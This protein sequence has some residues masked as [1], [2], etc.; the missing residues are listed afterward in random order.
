[1]K[2]NKQNT[3]TQHSNIEDIIALLTGTFLCSFALMLMQQAGI[4]TGGTAGLALLLHYATKLNFS[5][6]FFLV[7]IPFYYLAYKRLGT[8]MLLKTFV[9]IALLSIMT[10]VH[11]LFF[12]IDNID[13][14]Y[15][16]I[17]AN[18][19]IGIGLLILFRHR[20]S[21]GGFNLLALYIQEYYK[22]PAGK[23]QMAMD[24][25]VLIVSLAYISSKLLLISMIGVVILNLILA[26]N[27]RTDRYITTT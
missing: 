1:M 14:W 11:P 21:L 5:L 24:I 10:E 23:V 7:N 8:T 22:I 18:I 26:M 27:H 16:T 17:T 6:L 9:S 4:L 15:A 13:P 12:N 3:S 19:C 2:T 20:A 25:C